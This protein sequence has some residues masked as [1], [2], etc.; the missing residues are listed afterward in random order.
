M[1]LRSKSFSAPPA[2]SFILLH[3]QPATGLHTSY[4]NAGFGGCRKCR[5]IFRLPCIGLFRGDASFFESRL[6]SARVVTVCVSKSRAAPDLGWASSRSREAIYL[7][8]FDRTVRMA[9]GCESALVLVKANLRFEGRSGA[10]ANSLSLRTLQ[11]Q[12]F[13]SART[14]PTGRALC[15]LPSVRA[16]RQTIYRRV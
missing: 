12:R 1:G 14:A 8:A 5:P 15:A 2:I 10:I 3:M 7:S 11:N 4:Q 16:Q 6:K 13:C 9:R